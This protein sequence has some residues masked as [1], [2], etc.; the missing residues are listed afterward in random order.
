MTG[1]LYELALW[2]PGILLAMSIHEY[3]HAWVAVQLGDPTPKR[4]G[5]LTL[6]PVKH[7][8][9]IGLVLLILIHIGWAKPVP[10]QPANF[11]RP[12]RDMA[13]VALAGPLSNLITAIPVGILIRM[14]GFQILPGAI[15]GL[16]SIAFAF[17]FISL[18]L[19]VFNLF[20]LPPLDGWRI[21]SSLVGP[22]PWVLAMEQ[23]GV[24]ILLMV[25]VVL[26]RVG[27]D[28]LGIWIRPWMRL[29]GEMIL[30]IP[31]I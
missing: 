25:L 23:W 26:P 15:Q 19:A 10:V 3:A 20:P 6:D 31:L 28:V 16:E 27:V 13:L 30:G 8:D 18:I 5:R 1:F 2:L 4:M 29:A 12:R 11:R 9:P 14:G 24:L 21:T 22:R 17:V 7:I